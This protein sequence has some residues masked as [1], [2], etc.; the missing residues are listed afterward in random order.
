[1]FSLRTIAMTST[2]LLAWSVIACD[3][4]ELD[5][6]PLPE[7]TVMEDPTDPTNEDV[8][9]NAELAKEYLTKGEA[10]TWGAVTFVLAGL[11]GLQACRLDDQMEFRAN[12][13]YTYNG[14]DQL[15]GAEDDQ[16]IRTGTW[17]FS[18]EEGT[19]IFDADTD[20]EVTAEVLVLREDGLALRGSYLGL[21]VVGTY[22]TQ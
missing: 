13:T 19:M 3:L 1:M 9:S 6:P 8:P 17:A 20:M 4:V 2:M 18:A 5:D 14:G 12:G 11:E 10:R 7:E 21:E 22:R 16:R 15:C